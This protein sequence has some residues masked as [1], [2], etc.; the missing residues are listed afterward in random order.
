MKMFSFT[1]FLVVVMEMNF[2]QFA[3]TAG[4]KQNDTFDLSEKI[5][6]LLNIVKTMESRLDAK[7]NTGVLQDSMYHFRK[8]KSLLMEIAQ[9]QNLLFQEVHAQAR[10]QREIFDEILRQSEDEKDILDDFRQQLSQQTMALKTLKKRKR[11]S[12]QNNI[13]EKKG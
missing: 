2:V 4:K 10:Q 6:S 5:D 12:R 9:T 1:I 13:L 8:E 7:T 11:D 3:S